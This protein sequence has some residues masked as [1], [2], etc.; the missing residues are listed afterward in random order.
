[1]RQRDYEVGQA[2]LPFESPTVKLRFRSNQYDELILPPPRD[3]TFP[4]EHRIP[5]CVTGVGFREITPPINDAVGPLT[6]LPGCG[7]DLSHQPVMRDGPWHF[8]AVVSMGAPRRSAN[9][10]SRRWP[11]VS[12]R[13]NPYTSGASDSSRISAACC[14]ACSSD[15]DAPAP[16][17]R[18]EM[19]PNVARTTS[20]RFR[21]LL[22]QPALPPGS[23]RPP[24]H[25]RHIRTQGRLRLT[26]G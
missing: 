13:D 16:W 5:H 22:R 17:Q 18:P 7:G 10:T 23:P 6:Y 21:S 4:G 9:S 25:H 1:M 15:T 14:R 8:E 20:R 3:L 19:C 2:A 26:T 24:D 12:L 11:G